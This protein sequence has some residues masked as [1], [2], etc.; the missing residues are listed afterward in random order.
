MR[1]RSARTSGAGKCWSTIRA[2]QRNGER[3]STRYGKGSMNTRNAIDGPAHRNTPPPP[4][5]STSPAT[6]P[7]KKRRRSNPGSAAPRGV[8]GKAISKT[9]NPHQLPV[10]DWCTAQRA[11]AAP[12][13]P[14]G[15]E[16]HQIAVRVFGVVGPSRGHSVQGGPVTPHQR[17]P[18]AGSGE[19]M[20]SDYRSHDSPFLGKKSVPQQANGSKMD[21]AK[22]LPSHQRLQR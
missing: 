16:G 2:L 18:Q 14:C 12:K 7:G 6:L 5:H 10:H 20:G 22:S 17:K 3:H 11:S 4:M 1:P 19:P 21:L 8:Q 9:A 15:E 13:H